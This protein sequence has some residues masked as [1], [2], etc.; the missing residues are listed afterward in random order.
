MRNTV[1]PTPAATTTQGAQHFRL[2][3][4]LMF[5]GALSS[6]ITTAWH[7]A[8]RGS[9]FEGVVFGVAIV[10][11]LVAFKVLNNPV[12]AAALIFFSPF[13]FYA[14]YFASFVTHLAL[15]ML[16]LLSESEEATMGNRFSPSPVALFI[17]GLVGGFLLVGAVLW[18]MAAGNH[19]AKRALRWSVASGILAVVGWAL[20]PLLGPALSHVVRILPGQA[21]LTP[22]SGTPD[23]PLGMICSVFF[24]WQ[25]GMGFAI[26]LMVQSKSPIPDQERE[27]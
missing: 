21:R 8:S 24:V 5:L 7:A 18:L 4:A 20:S 25:V 16:G 17:G 22:Q 26:G 12:K 14:A 15:A 23:G 10:C 2:P 19:R 1:A 9:V 6:F 13:A 3:I 27:Q 11:G